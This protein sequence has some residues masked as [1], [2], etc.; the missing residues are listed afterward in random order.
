IDTHKDYL[1]AVRKLAEE[2]QVAFIDLAAKSK[3]LYE[4]LGPEGT[5]TIFLWGD[6]GEWLNH[7]NGVR[8]NT[9]FQEKGGLA[10][11]KLVVEGIRELRLQPLTMFMR[12][13]EA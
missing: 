6:R 3:K 10:L 12:P 5:K 8:D 11:A 13:T 9:H 2:E 7:P 4:E 1:D